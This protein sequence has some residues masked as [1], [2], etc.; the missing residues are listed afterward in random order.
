MSNVY[1]IIRENKPTVKV[2]GRQALIERLNKFKA[3]RESVDSV[4]LVLSNNGLYNDIT[5]HYRQYIYEKVNRLSLKE[6]WK[7]MET[8][9][10]GG[11]TEDLPVIYGLAVYSDMTD[12]TYYAICKDK[13]TLKAHRKEIIDVITDPNG[14]YEGNPSAINKNIGNLKSKYGI[15]LASNEDGMEFKVI[16]LED[17]KAVNLDNTMY[18]VEL[19]DTYSSRF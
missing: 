19:V 3:R 7:L 13:E 11:F 10:G 9:E 5:D 2:A 15:M 4:Y 16:E 6:Q 17:G 14:E 18:K 8:Y 1:E 12:I